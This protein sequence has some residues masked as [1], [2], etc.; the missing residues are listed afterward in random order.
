MK[1]VIKLLTI[2][3]IAMLILG[4]S[5]NAATVSMKTSSK[6]VTVNQ[7]VSITVSFGE[8]LSAAQFK[9]NYDK[10][11]FDYISC[12]TG[13]FGTG[14]N[15]WAYLSWTDTADMGSVTFKF[16]AKETGTGKFSI[17]GVVPKNANISS[18]SVTVKVEEA[19]KP[20]TNSG[21][22]SNSGSS[23]TSKPS[24]NTNNNKK[25]TSTTNKDKNT[26]SASTEP[27][28]ENTEPVNE[29]SVVLEKTELNNLKNILAERDSE[30]YTEESWNALQEVI[31][32]AENATTQE[33]Y[34]ALKDKLV[35]DNLEVATFEKTELHKVLIDLIGKSKNDYTEESWNE[36]QEAIEEA[37]NADNKNEYEKVKSKLTVSGLILKDQNFIE[38]LFD[39]SCG[40]NMAII[41]LI[42]STSV[43]LL[44]TIALAVAYA[45]KD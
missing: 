44:T 2:M 29:E 45:K 13:D 4:T 31:K 19:S 14:T 28:N 25:P 11:K 20:S 5:A 24:S 10:N 33:E 42:V 3:I 40:H 21:S 1:K 26:S 39:D 36:L 27:V 22:N 43:F 32:S 12:S 8:K 9:L 7:T 18:S 35:L 34:E 6:T 16:K 37:N 23:S 15:I 38:W 17:S 30:N 41:G